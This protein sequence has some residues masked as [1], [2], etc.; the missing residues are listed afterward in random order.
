M[1]NFIGKI[2]QKNSDILD[3]LNS[4]AS[5]KGVSATDTGLDTG[6]R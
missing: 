6:K 5:G 1:K 2:F 3:R 4:L